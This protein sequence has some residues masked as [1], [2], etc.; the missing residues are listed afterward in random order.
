M[1]HLAPVR[2][3]VVLEDGTLMIHQNGSL[4]AWP[5]IGMLTTGDWS[6]AFYPDGSRGDLT[7]TGRAWSYCD[8]LS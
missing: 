2:A 7:G 3:G 4:G 6:R 1:G 8:A 5:G